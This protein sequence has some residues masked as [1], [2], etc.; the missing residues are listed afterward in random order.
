VQHSLTFAKVSVLSQSH[1]FDMPLHVWLNATHILQ[2]HG[3]LSG[4]HVCVWQT[5]IQ[6]YKTKHDTDISLHSVRKCFLYSSASIQGVKALLTRFSLL[7]KSLAKFVFGT[8]MS[9]VCN[10]FSSFG[11]CLFAFCR[12]V[13]SNCFY[14]L[15]CYPIHVLILVPL[16]CLR[17]PCSLS[18]CTS[19]YILVVIILILYFVF[20]AHFLIAC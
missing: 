10:L 8:I 4:L 15:K 1:C 3:Y 14:V 18:P 12:H 17:S 16:E 19:P 11:V 13:E 5:Q 9:V 20:I 6:F 7:Q 2:R